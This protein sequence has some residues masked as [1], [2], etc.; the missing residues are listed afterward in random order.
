[1]YVALLYMYRYNFSKQKRK[2]GL[3]GF[4]Y[5]LFFSDLI[6]YMY[7][8]KERFSFYKNIQ[9][10][11]YEYSL[12]CTSWILSPHTCSAQVL[13]P[14]VNEKHVNRVYSYLSVSTRIG[15]ENIRIA[16]QTVWPR[17]ASR[18]VHNVRNRTE[19]HISRLFVFSKIDSDMKAR[20]EAFSYGAVEFSYDGIRYDAMITIK[21]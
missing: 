13:F 6:I 3:F 2:N 4:S 15:A 10:S 19:S 16:T 8:L 9:W 20:L 21:L 5:I 1:L 18:I 11:W 7:F 14:S 17:K 12:V